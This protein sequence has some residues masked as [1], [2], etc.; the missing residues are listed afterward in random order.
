MHN[1]FALLL[2][3]SFILLS[4]GNMPPGADGPL[5]DK[6]GERLRQRWLV[7]SDGSASRA[8]FYDSKLNADCTFQQTPSGWMCLPSGVAHTTPGLTGYVTAEIVTQSTP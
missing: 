7:A 1:L 5:Q 2:L 8:W 3:L 6:G 4:C